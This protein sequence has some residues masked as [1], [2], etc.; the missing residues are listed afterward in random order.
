[1]L[2]LRLRQALCMLRLGL[3]VYM[4]IPES[5]CLVPHVGAEVEACAVHTEVRVRGVHGL[6]SVCVSEF[7]MLALRLRQALCMLRLVLGVY[8]DI[9]ES[10]CLSSS[11]WR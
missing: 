5:V 6:T 11:C 10:V 1:M 8:I 9:P 4:D 2:A 3:G 7:L